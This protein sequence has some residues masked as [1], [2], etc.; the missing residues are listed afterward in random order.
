MEGQFSEKTKKIL[1][2]IIIGFLT[3]FIIIFLLLKGCS[4]QKHTVTFDSNGGTTV[5]SIK[6][7]DND[8]V[9]RPEDPTKDGYIFDGWYLEDELFD[10]DTKIRK[11]ITLEAYW[12]SNS[13]EL[14]ST[15]ISLVVGLEKKLEILSLPDGITKENLVYSSSD[16]SIVTVDENGNL[17]AL[18]IGTVT[19]TIKS[20]D[21]KYTAKCTV[22]VMD[23]EIESISID[24]DS[25]VTVGN[26]IQLTV[27]FNPS[28]ATSKKLT[29]KSSDTSIATIDENGNVKGLNVGTVTITV[30]TT[31]GKEATK[32]ITVTA[33]PT[34]QNNNSGGFENQS[35]NQNQ[36]Q[37]GN[38]NQNENQGGGSNTPKPPKIV[39]P[40]GVIITGENEVYIGDIIQLSATV[41]PNNATNKNVTWN[42][43]DTSI[44]TVDENGKVT[45]VNAGTVI[46][47]VTTANGK[48]S[49]YEVKVKEKEPTYVIY[50]TKDGNLVTGGAFNYNF[51]VEKNGDIFVDYLGFTFNN[52]QVAKDQGHVSA[53]VVDAGGNQASLKLFDGTVVIATVVIE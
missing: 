21:G 45:G 39:E 2:G 34:Y 16:E 1:I 14:K 23:E 40:S 35:G 10:F 20:K 38:Q 25:T 13:I 52:T 37:N 3:I 22:N 27:T 28:N 11:D 46:I 42:S 31:N 53:T 48:T 30:T 9:K 8:K 17:N 4:A 18:T 44:A 7:K 6:V 29:W 5:K 33:R 24:G 41:S 32:E 15:S 19:I 49:T 50:L 47:T 26:S 36:N 12:N 51:R 43:S